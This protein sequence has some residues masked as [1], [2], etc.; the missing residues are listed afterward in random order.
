MGLSDL[1]LAARTLSRHRGFTIVAVSSLALAI[2]LN[3]TM[4]SV[5]DAMIRPRISARSPEDLFFTRYYGDDPRKHDP[6]AVE[7]AL[8]ESMPGF[9]GVSGADRLPFAGRNPLVENG[10][11]Y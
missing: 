3:T 1:R 7:R 2:A 11:R 5:L 8:R 4:Y 9:E 10:T 6:A